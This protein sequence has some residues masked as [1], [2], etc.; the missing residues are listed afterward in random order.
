M[1]AIERGF[2]DM[3][4]MQKERT[5][6]DTLKMALAFV[7]EQVNEKRAQLEELEQLT[8]TERI[9]NRVIKEQINKMH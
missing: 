6:L 5:D 7:K 3:E 9:H 1:G 8:K 2:K 4:F